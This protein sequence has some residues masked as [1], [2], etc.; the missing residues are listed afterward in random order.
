VQELEKTLGALCSVMLIVTGVLVLLFFNIERKAFDSATYKQ[1]F[2]AQGLYQRMPAL[3]ASALQTSVSQNPNAF[4]FLKELS[5][6][7][8]QT[9]IASLLPPEE[10]RAIA[11]RALDSTF[12]YVNGRSNSVVLSLAPLKVHLAGQEGVNIIKQFLSTQPDCTVDQLTQMGL[13]LLGGNIALCN[14]PDQAMSLVEP[15]IASQLQTVVAAFPDQ[16]TLLSGTDSRSP[17]DPRYT[18]HLVRSA[19]RFSPFLVFLLLLA[20]TLFAV[21]SIRDWLVWWGIPFL[22]IGITTAL[23]ALVGSPLVGWLLQFVIETRGAALVPPILASSI[24]ETTSAVARQIL[25]PVAIQALIIAVI[26]LMMLI[27]GILLTRR[28][29]TQYYET[30]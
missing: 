17:G 30:Y 6:E 4:P 21:R 12:D 8:W 24:A 14:P 18:L 19:I 3:M 23:I 7:D 26:G 16:V 27:A 28:E 10:S 5:P 20:L 1:A 2:E 11:D 22:V 13:G 25:N 15:L 29:T 9:T